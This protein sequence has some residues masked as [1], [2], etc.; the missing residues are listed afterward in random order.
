MSL[1]IPH[2]ATSCTPGAVGCSCITN[3]ILTGRFS[4]VSREKLRVLWCVL[5][6]STRS[7]CACIPNSE[8]RSLFVMKKPDKVVFV[9]AFFVTMVAQLIAQ[10][11]AT[12]N[13]T[14]GSAAIL[15]LRYQR[16]QFI[17]Q[18]QVVWWAG[19]RSV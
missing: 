1:S 19:F 14:R 5:H 9:F 2:R 13:C 3:P 10:L 8:G 16:S 11:G 17:N 4:A 12:L 6:K 15:G 7:V 18:V